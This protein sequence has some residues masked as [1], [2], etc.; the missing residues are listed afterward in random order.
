MT[1]EQLKKYDGTDE[2]G[3]VC[4]AV[5]GKVFDVTRGKKFYGPGIHIIYYKFYSG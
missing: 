4:V 1:L 2:E 5:N 3:R